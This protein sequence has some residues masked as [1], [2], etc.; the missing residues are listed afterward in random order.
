MTI[1]FLREFNRKDGDF[2]PSDLYL[3]VLRLKVLEKVIDFFD[4][5]DII[6]TT[7]EEHSKGLMPMIV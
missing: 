5:Y 4:I 3:D 6:I 2:S 7:S 1:E